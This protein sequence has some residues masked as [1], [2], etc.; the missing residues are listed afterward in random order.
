[1]AR[2]LAKDGIRVLQRRARSTLFPGGSWERR[3]RDD[4][5]GCAAFIERELPLGRLGTVDEI[6]DVVTFLFR[7]ARPGSSGRASPSTAASRAPSDAAWARRRRRDPTH[8]YPPMGS[9]AAPPSVRGARARPGGGVAL[10]ARRSLLRDARPRRAG[11]AVRV[12]TPFQRDRDR[13]RPLEA[14]SAAEG[15]DAGLHRPGRAT[16]T[17]PG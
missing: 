15:Q 2:D 10:A 16:T 17:A 8:D 5:R 9:Q 7:R 12:R 4:P 11:G 3:T 1:M 13:H 14:V 6:A